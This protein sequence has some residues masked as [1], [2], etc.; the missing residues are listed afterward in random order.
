MRVVSGKYRSRV[1]QSF[2]G[3]DIRPTSDMTKESLFNIL[4]NVSGISFL[5]LFAGTGNMGIECISRGGHSTFTDISKDSVRIIKKNLEMLNE[6]AEVY[7]VNAIYFL[8]TDTKKYDVIFIDPP[9]NSDLGYQA[10][11]EIA[12]NKNLKENGVAV[13]ESDKQGE[14]VEGLT[15]TDRRRYGK[16]HLTFYRYE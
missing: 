2:K 9:Y 15:V 8:A 1:L 14:N 5:D 16:A 11:K 12:K 7:T 6:S 10:L 4:G 3:Q 13:F